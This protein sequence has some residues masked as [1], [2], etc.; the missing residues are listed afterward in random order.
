M[1]KPSRNS[2]WARLSHL[3]TA[4]ANLYVIIIAALLL[5]LASGVTYYTNQ[6]T[7][8]K[9]MEQLV[10]REMTIIHLTIQNKFSDV[11]NVLNN[12]SWVVSD[13]LANPD[14]L[15][16]VTRKLVANNPSILG[17]GIMCIPDYYPAYGRWFE[18]YSAR[19]SDGAIETV[20]LASTDHDYFNKEF[21][22]VSVTTGNSHW[23][24]PYLDA[25]GAKEVV[26]TYCVPVRDKQGK[27]IGVVTADLSLDW[28]DEIVNESKIYKSNERFLVTGRFNILVGEDSDLYRTALAKIKAAK[29][30]NGYFAMGEDEGPLKH[31]FYTPV[32]GRT[33]WMLISILD[34]EEVFGKLRAVRRFLV[35]MALLTLHEFNKRNIHNRY[36]F[37]AKIIKLH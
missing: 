19:R 36:F 13:N 33:N 31:V 5:I 26:T 15:F 22:T 32:G 12:M 3:M 37:A 20:Q 27:V 9:T 30:R 18:P 17:C 23:C 24:E 10:G 16:A 28:L 6:R 7:I 11:E 8:Q 14:S 4:H 2:R 21:F 35:S 25:D 34:D 29:N 1:N